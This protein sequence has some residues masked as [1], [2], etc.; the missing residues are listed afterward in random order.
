MFDDHTLVVNGSCHRAEGERKTVFKKNGARISAF[1]PVG[2]L[3]VLLV[4]SACSTTQPNTTPNNQQAI[5]L[6]VSLSLTGD[7]SADGQATLRGY[8]LWQDFTN[9]HGGLLGRQVQ[10]VYY[11]DASKTEQTQTNYE[12]LI[13]IDHVDFTVGPFGEDFTVTGAKVAARHGYAFLEGIGTSPN[14]FGQGLKNLF[15]VSLSATAYLSSFDHYVL[16]L[17]ADMRPKSVAYVTSDDPF[18]LPQVSSARPILEQGGIRTTTYEVYPAETTDF[19][20]VAQKVI[21]SAPDAVVLGSVGLED[22]KAILQYFKQQ[23]FNPK[24]IVAT[25]GPDQGAD[26]LNAMGGARGAEGL[27][28]PNDGWFPK[29]HS[30]QNDQFLQ[31]YLHKF[32]GAP[33]DISSDSV[34][35]FSTG[36]VLVQA[37][38]EAKSLDNGALMKVLRDGTFQSLQ[39]VVKFAGDGENSLALPFLFQWQKGELI[40]V[41]PQGQAQAN[42]EYPKPNWP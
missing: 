3:L 41:Y 1:L 35:A 37:I 39:G 11:N 6:G 15:A 10:V 18:T 17:P 4:S 40:P 29:L 33:A 8:Q 19:K 22:C 5:K 30:F 34:Q 28:V 25:A 27:L 13:S 42:L 31:A 16:S 20:P 32:G 23:H 26:F 12:K 36:Q 2:V 7:N 9:Q 24:I 14:T 21:A 38:T